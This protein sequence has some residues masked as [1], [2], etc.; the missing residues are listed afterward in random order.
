MTIQ[1]WGALMEAGRKWLEVLVWPIFWVVAIKRLHPQIVQLIE[2]LTHFTFKGWGFETQI[3]RTTSE[4]S[5]LLSAAEL[6]QSQ[7]KHHKGLSPEQVSHLAK[8]VSKT[9]TPQMIRRAEQSKILWVDDHPE[10]NAYERQS[11]EAMGVQFDI[12]RSTEEAIEKVNLHRFNVIISDMGR[13]LDD[14]AGYTLLA[15]L[16]AMKNFIPYV[17]YAGSNSPEYKAEAKMKGALGSTNRASELF[18]YVHQ[19]LGESKQ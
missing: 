12:A 2:G 9:V 19:A 13:P 10:N 16:R 1:E 6:K 17:I 7:E 5:A 14:R 4:V 15:Q 11:L 3:I 18:A 8:V